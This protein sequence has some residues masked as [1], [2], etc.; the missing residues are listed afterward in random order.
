MATTVT[1]DYDS[2][3]IVAALDKVDESFSDLT[4]SSK[5]VGDSFEEMAGELL[6]AADKADAAASDIQSLESNLSDAEDAAGGLHGRVN[7]LAQALDN[8][9]KQT[10]FSSKE[11]Q[12]LGREA[13]DLGK[14]LQ[15]STAQ[16][17][18]AAEAFDDFIPTQAIAKVGAI[19]GLIAGVG[20]SVEKLI[21][22]IG[23]AGGLWGE[24]NEGIPVLSTVDGL[25]NSVGNSIGDILSKGYNWLDSLRGIEQR[26]SAVNAEI[27]TAA[28]ANNQFVQSSKDLFALQS[29]FNRSRADAAAAQRINEDAAK[30]TTVQMVDAYMELLNS[31]RARMDVLEATPA[32]VEREKEIQETILALENRRTQIIEKQKREDQERAEQ[33]ERKAQEFARNEE[34]RLEERRQSEQR[35]HEERLKRAE[36]LQRKND[37]NNR[38]NIEW[39]LEQARKADELRKEEI[40][41][42]FDFA[43]QKQQALTGGTGGGGTPAPLGG[44]GASTLADPLAKLGPFGRAAM[45]GMTAGGL[46]SGGAVVSQGIGRFPG[47]MGPDGGMVGPGGVGGAA[48]PAGV[49][50]PG[51]TSLEDQIKATF[52]K[53]LEKIDDHAVEQRA[54]ENF[55]KDNAGD[56]D[57]NWKMRN[58]RRIFKGGGTAD[59]IGQARKQLED[60]AQAEINARL[61]ALNKQGIVNDKQLDATKRAI[62]EYKNTQ[63]QLEATQ[64]DLDEVMQTLNIVSAGANNREARR[65]AQRGARGN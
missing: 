55:Q 2:T 50:G 20:L 56:Q 62:E 12:A 17:L 51:G 4:K 29:E 47:V 31:E 45:L 39:Q 38:R 13:G 46:A 3:K 44:D 9:E 37:E 35:E 41:S 28:E 57:E 14:T 53:A 33:K 48:G 60:E 54:W 59:E 24:F 36:E 43:K 30:Q 65:R 34:R 11:V 15:G 1:A 52:G 16:M 26:W 63:Q 7:V 40:K 49:A 27:A 8:F 21:H 58:R 5:D 64:A 10:K 19:A 32:M 6:D 61:E 22:D 23:V 42:I 18:L 25:F